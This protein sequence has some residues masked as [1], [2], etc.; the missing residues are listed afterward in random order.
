MLPRP[1]QKTIDT[2]KLAASLL[3]RPARRAFQAQTVLDHCN[4]NLSLAKTL[5]GW[6]QETVSRGLLELEQGEAIA[7]KPGRGRKKTTELL[8]MLESDIR[9][10]VDPNSQTHPT[11]ETSFRYTRM[12]AKAVREA[13]V[14]E[15]GYKL[16]ELPAESTM[17]DLLGKM[18]YCLR[19]VQKTKPQKKF[20]KQMR[21]SRMSTPRTSEATKTTKHYESR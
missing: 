15:K 20:P 16:E 5:F 13:L 7:D 11:F 14:K 4:G 21:S 12:T 9:S 8:P 1:D 18:G 2:I 19:R 6:H 17:R 10:L 3:S